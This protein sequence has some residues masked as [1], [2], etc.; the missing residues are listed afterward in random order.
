MLV[1]LNALTWTSGERSA[2]LAID[3]KAALNA[4]VDLLLVHE[5]PDVH[6]G[7][8]SKNGVDFGK[9]FACAAGAT[10]LEL[11]QANVYR[12]VAVPL[13]DG[14]FR[15]ASMLLI[16]DSLAQY[17]KLRRMRF[18]A[19]TQRRWWRSFAASNKRPAVVKQAAARSA[20]LSIRYSR[21][22]L[23]DAEPDARSS[24]GE[25]ACRTICARA[26]DAL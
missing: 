21:R 7:G 16:A 5:T 22:S 2:L 6:G 24:A 13:K 14:A 1:Y 15:P 3:V 17:D 11:I 4:G 8:G 26:E 18:N 25:L 9:F 12:N 10:P 23:S 20:R 19:Q